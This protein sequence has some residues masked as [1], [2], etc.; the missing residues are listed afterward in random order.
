MRRKMR[1]LGKET[2]REE[3]ERDHPSTGSN[4][5]IVWLKKVKIIEANA[6]PD[7]IHTPLGV[8]RGNVRLAELSTSLKAQPVSSPYRARANHPLSGWS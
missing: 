5:D 7:H 1:I 2:V 3:L 4:K 6:C 8:L